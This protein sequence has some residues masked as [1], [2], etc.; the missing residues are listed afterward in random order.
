MP[1]RARA[2]LCSIGGMKTHA[3]QNY[4]TLD[5]LRGVA[6]VMVV[7]FHIMETHMALAG[8]DVAGHVAEPHVSGG[9]FLLPALGVRAGLCL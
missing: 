3:K 1:W 7:V 6:A 9:G 4:L 8:G 5:A 2:R